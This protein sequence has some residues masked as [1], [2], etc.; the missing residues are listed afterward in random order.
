MERRTQHPAARPSQRQ[1]SPGCRCV[2]ADALLA[3][4]ACVPWERP[5]HAARHAFLLRAAHPGERSL[6]VAC[7]TDR[8]GFIDLAYGLTTILTDISD[9]S[10]QTLAQQLADL[11]Q[12]MGAV[13]GAAEFRCLA[14]EDLAGPQGFAPASIHHLTLQN[15]FN[16][17]LH[18][19]QAHV[20]IVEALLAIITDAGTC[21][22]TESEGLLL[23]KRA[24]IRGMRVARLGQIPGYYD[25]GVLMLRVHKPAL[26]ASS[27]ASPF[28]FP[29]RSPIMRSR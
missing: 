7:G 29:A 28:P 22:I 12:G 10:L 21:F 8:L 15:L 19:P 5:V 13:A 25:E 16:A 24:R 17:Q 6:H 4:T 9:A 27:Q 20:S 11:Q 18:S 3:A 2:T 26:H 23:E 1:A 14:V